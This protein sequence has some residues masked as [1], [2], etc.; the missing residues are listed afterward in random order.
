LIGLEWTAV[1]SPDGV[2]CMVASRLRRR[3]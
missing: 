2:T 3:P 1:V